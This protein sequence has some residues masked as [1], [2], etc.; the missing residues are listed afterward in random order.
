MV[1]LLH[2]CTPHCEC[3]LAIRKKAGNTA[4][5]GFSVMSDRERSLLFS[6]IRSSDR[7]MPLHVHRLWHNIVSPYHPARERARAHRRPEAIRTHD[8]ILDTS[9]IDATC[10]RA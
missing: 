2:S 4:L 1:I 6:S 10:G 8:G 3:L 7:Y 9:A 5:F